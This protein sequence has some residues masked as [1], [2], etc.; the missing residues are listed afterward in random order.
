MKGH[1][2]VLAPGASSEGAY[3]H[4]GEGFIIV[5]SGRIEIALEGP[6]FHELGAGDSLSFESRRLQFWRNRFDG[7]TVIVWVKHPATFDLAMSSL[8]GSGF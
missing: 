7:E 3:H 2:F 8:S 4:E 6:E 5:E 1:R